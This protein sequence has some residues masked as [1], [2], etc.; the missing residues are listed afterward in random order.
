MYWRLLKIINMFLTVFIIFAIV[1]TNVIFA[2]DITPQEKTTKTI[3]TK[4][5][6]ALAEVYNSNLSG[7]G[8]PSSVNPDFIING[9]KIRV[10][11]EF[12]SND[13]VVPNNLGIEVETTYENMV[14]ALVPIGNLEALANNDDV[15]FVRMPYQA[16]D[17]LETPSE[18][19]TPLNPLLF[20]IAIP[21][22]ALIIWKIRK[23][24]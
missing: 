12:Y 5:D 11:I 19:P 21:I 15:K 2:Q 17:G 3:Q 10:I 14:Q 9:N 18:N 22:I 4:M 7:I 13:Y 20:L 6:S 8:I 23:N 24:K 16:G 1:G